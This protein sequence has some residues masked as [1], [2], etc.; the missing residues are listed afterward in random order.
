MLHRLDSERRHRGAGAV[1]QDLIDVT[2]ELARAGV[3]RARECEIAAG[4]AR[5]LQRFEASDLEILV[6]YPYPMPADHIARTG[7]RIGRD[8]NA[9]GERLE[10]YDA[11]CV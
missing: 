4:R 7:H 1:M 6:Q 2:E 11:E 9:A 3:P 10:L 8:R 5:D